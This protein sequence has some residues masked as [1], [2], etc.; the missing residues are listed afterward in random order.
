MNKIYPL[1]ILLHKFESNYET[2]EFKKRMRNLKKKDYL[3]VW[4]ETYLLQFK[5]RN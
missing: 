2:E 1:Y 3:G 4:A 5:N